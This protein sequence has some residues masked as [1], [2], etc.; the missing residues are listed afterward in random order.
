M[1]YLFC[2]VRSSPIRDVARDQ[3][4]IRRD[5][6]RGQCSPSGQD[7]GPAIRDDGI[8]SVRTSSVPFSVLPPARWK[9]PCPVLFNGRIRPVFGCKT[10]ILRCGAEFLE[11]RRSEPAF[12]EHQVDV[13]QPSEVAMR[14]TF[15]VGDEDVAACGRKPGRKRPFYMDG[16]IRPNG[17]AESCR[18]DRDR[19][20]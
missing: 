7:A 5:G 4:H 17:G 19:A 13:F 8:H 6:F 9:T 12:A 2:I 15:L 18:R 10:E 1:P 14:K 16:G 11:Y 3:V 20:G